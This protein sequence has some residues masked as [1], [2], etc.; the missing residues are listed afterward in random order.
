MHGIDVGNSNFKCRPALQLFILVQRAVVEKKI[1]QN[2]PQVLIQLRDVGA[3]L[4]A[5]TT[6]HSSMASTTVSLT[7]LSR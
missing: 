1:S 3:S 2:A 6:N 7:K 5:V 4:H